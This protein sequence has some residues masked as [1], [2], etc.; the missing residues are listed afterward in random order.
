MAHLYDSLIIVKSVLVYIMGPNAVYIHR[1]LPDSFKC[2]VA[3][4][5]GSEISTRCN[6]DMSLADLAVDAGGLFHGSQSGV[7]MK[8]LIRSQL[9]LYSVTP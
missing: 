6:L 1:S 4:H 2:L 7:Y 9:P 3:R 5:Q 8:I